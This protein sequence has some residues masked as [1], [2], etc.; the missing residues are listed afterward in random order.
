MAADAASPMKSLLHSGRAAKSRS[1][2]RARG[3]T[4][5]ESYRALAILDQ[6][7]EAHG[8]KRLGRKIGF[9]NRT[10]WSNTRSTRR[11]G[12]TSTIPRCMI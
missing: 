10:I 7:R 5:D 9:T 3:L 2:R 1:S 8:E 6:M 4:L 11:T 12:A